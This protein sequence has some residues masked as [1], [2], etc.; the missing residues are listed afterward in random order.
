MELQIEILKQ[1]T[2]LVEEEENIELDRAE[3]SDLRVEL[4][5]EQED[6]E[7]QASSEKGNYLEVSFVAIYW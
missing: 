6:Q 5:D 3:L 1:V 2:D 7:L 4:I